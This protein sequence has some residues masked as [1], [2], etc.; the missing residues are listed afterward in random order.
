MSNLRIRDSLMT[1]S[2]VWQR[3]FSDALLAPR[4]FRRVMPEFRKVSDMLVHPGIGSLE[5]GALP[6]PDAPIQM[7][8]I[9]AGYGGMPAQDLYALV[10]V[11]RWIKPA[12]IFEIGTFQGATTAH[13]AFNSEAEIYT[14]DLPRDLALDVHGYTDKDLALLQSRQEIG[15][16]YRAQSGSARIHQVFG[17]SRTFNYEP[18]YGSMDV[19]LVDAC[20][21]YD[22]V[23]SDSH[24]AF[25]LLGQRGAV[26]WHDFGNS[27]DVLRALQQI[28]CDHVITHLEGTALALY[29]RGVSGI[30]QGARDSQIQTAE[31]VA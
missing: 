7:L 1:L 4:R 27:R 5:V 13:M 22:Y 3:T 2:T 16:A 9:S 20:H 10:R 11:L 19:V 23:I 24:A 30:D 12:R 8:S 28:A 26:L 15:K 21:L 25:R 29:T 18:Y 6:V 31:A 14:L 17:D